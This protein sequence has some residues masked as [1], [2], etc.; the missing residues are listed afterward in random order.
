MSDSDS[1]IYNSKDY[2]VRLDRAQCSLN[3]L[4]HQ[5]GGDSYEAIKT[6]AES[7]AYWQMRAAN[8]EQFF[9]DEGHGGLRL[10]SPRDDQ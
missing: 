10:K 7:I 5:H 1:E 8:A 4:I 9:F 6:A 2:Q 3:A